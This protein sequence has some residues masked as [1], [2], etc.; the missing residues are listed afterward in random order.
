MDQFKDHLRETVPNIDELWDPNLPM[1][2]NIS[3][4][5][6]GEAQ[7]DS[8]ARCQRQQQVGSGG[9]TSEMENDSVPKSQS[10][11]FLRQVLPNI[12]ELWNPN[13]TVARNIARIDGRGASTAQGENTLQEEEAVDLMVREIERFGRV[14]APRNQPNPFPAPQQ[15]ATEGLSSSQPEVYTAECKDIIRSL[16]RP[17]PDN[18]KSPLLALQQQVLNIFKHGPERATGVFGSLSAA[19]QSGLTKAKF[20]DSDLQ[21]SWKS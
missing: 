18:L 20:P 4:V 12:D 2:L 19:A 11:D 16:C 15:R 14:S 1:A 3:R 13:L 21:L 6:S 10:P 17:A 9:S 8:E 5:V 7:A